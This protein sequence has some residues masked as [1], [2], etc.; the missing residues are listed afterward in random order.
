MLEDKNP[1]EEET[2]EQIPENEEQDGIED[3]LK[4]IAYAAIGG[5]ADVADNIAEAARNVATKE[6]ID[7]L[8]VK[9]EKAVKKVKEVS[10]NVAK[11]AVSLSSDAI[12]KIK[13]IIDEIDTDD[14]QEQLTDIKHDIMDS[15][16][17]AEEA[18]DDMPVDKKEEYQ[19]IIK[20]LSRQKDEISALVKKLRKITEEE[21]RRIKEEKEELGISDENFYSDTDDEE[22]R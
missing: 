22:N 18:L 11:Q 5:V 13:S 9:G 17:N 19:G 8:T 20:E 15:L 16:N 12:E 6:N 1:I 4:R 3:K 10:E 2:K 14:P 21:N 7:R